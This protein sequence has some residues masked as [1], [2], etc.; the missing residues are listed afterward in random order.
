[1]K[2]V[3]QYNW[4]IVILL[5][6]ISE[7]LIYPLGEFPL[8][9]DWAYTKPIFSFLNTGEI[10]FL[11]WQ[12]IPGVTLQILGLL[13]C[14][15]FG[16]SFFSLR[17]V[18][19]LSTIIMILT[20]NQILKFYE[21]VS[22]IRFIVL[23]VF[24]FNPLVLSLSNTF[25][26]DILILM[27]TMVAFLFM[28]RLIKNFQ[29][30]TYVLFIVFTLL[31]T[32][33]R[34]TGIILPFVFAITYLVIY[35]VKFKNIL[36]SFSPFILN[37]LILYI[38]VYI[39]KFTGNMT[40]T[41]NYQFDRI[42]HV[43][44]HPTLALIKSFLYYFITSTI[45]IGIFL[46]P[47]TLSNIKTHLTLLKNNF[48]LLIVATI[49]LFLIL[50]KV[51][52]SENILPTV[53]NIIYSSGI[54]PIILAEFQPYETKNMSLILKIFWQ[55]LNL[56][57]GISFCCFI[58]SIFNNVFTKCIN[59]K[60]YLHH[61]ILLL[62]IFYLFPICLSFANDRYLLF[63]LPFLLL[64]YVISFSLKFKKILFLIPFSVLTYFSVA[65]TH[66]YFSFHKTRWKAGNHL[67]EEL[68]IA[69]SNIDGGFEF[70]AW[71]LYG[72]K[73]YN[74]S[75]TGNWWWVEN[76]HYV[77]APTIIEGYNIQA[78]Y[79]YSTWLPNNLKHL[80]VLKKTNNKQE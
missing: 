29:L 66:D 25:M 10:T 41:F 47:L 24:L 5:F 70:N 2:K 71:H 57:G 60:N 21:V 26:P 49:Y 42:I 67:T 75:H 18:S 62:F 1:M 77:I 39:L 53:G 3:I 61:L 30:H 51:I 65:G 11:K 79:N 56:L 68:A 78:E 14:K 28:I 15:I 9:D 16:T 17:L 44:S 7:I 59:K 13:F 34:Q 20:L 12:A 73:S 37:I 69:P 58:I 74:P 8:N 35:P 50:I 19:I 6:I 31:A 45:C 55:S 52:I 27:L 80:Y 43:I 22:K 40:V 46:L 54:G 32:L 76:N 4:V 38:Y 23:L 36:I 64:I 72:S 63:L 33:V 48:K